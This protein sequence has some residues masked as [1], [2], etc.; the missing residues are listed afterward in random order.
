MGRAFESNSV[1][2]VE[3][4][5]ACVSQG[6]GCWEWTAAKSKQGYGVFKINYRQWKAHRLSYMIFKGAI[7]DGMM[8]LHGCDNT[9]CVNPL[10]LRTGDAADNQMDAV[11]RGRHSKSKKKVCSKGHTYTEQNTYWYRGGRQCN[12]CRSRLSSEA[13]QR[14]KLKMAAQR[15]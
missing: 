6:D 13:W 9:S 2:M 5:M 3:K 15:G 4:F 11:I 10:H 8:V 1:N 7:P 12:K 14:R